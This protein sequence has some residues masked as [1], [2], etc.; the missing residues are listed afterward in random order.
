LRSKYSCFNAKKKITGWYG[1][2]A[3]ERKISEMFSCNVIEP[4]MVKEQILK[5]AVEV[6]NLLVRVD[7][8][9]MA[10][11]VMNTHTHEDG[12]KHSHHGG[13]KKHDHY[14]DKLGKQQRPL[15]HYY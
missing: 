11:P 8:V 1:V 14:F 7:D 9:L 2:D 12:T 6:T 10:K 3:I 15:H 4:T 5:T 13:D